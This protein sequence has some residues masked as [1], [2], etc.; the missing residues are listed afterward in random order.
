MWQFAEACRGLKDACALLG[1]PVTGGNVSLYNQTGETAILPT[2]V[3]AVL[4]VIDDVRRRT[5]TGFVAEGEVIVHLGQTREELSG[6]EWA[7]VVHGHLGGLPPQ[8]D[9]RDEAN[10]ARLLVEAARGRYLT[11]AHDMSEGG[12]SQALVE[13]C[14]RHGVGATVDL[15]GDPFVGLF[16]ESAA[17]AIVTV[18]DDRLDSFLTMAASLGVPAGPVGRTGGGSLTVTDRF[19]IPLEELSAAWRGTLRDAFGS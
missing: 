10:L 5:P 17:R 19:E 15:L 7:H 18:P 16:S 11:S 2:P 13:S 8:V 14:L 1:V 12:L 6:S 4:G 9:L 3:V